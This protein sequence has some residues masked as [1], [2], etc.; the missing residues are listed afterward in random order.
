[1]NLKVA[2]MKVVWEGE[3]IELTAVSDPVIQPRLREIIT[4]HQR[5]WGV[6]VFVS[7]TLDEEQRHLVRLACDLQFVTPDSERPVRIRQY[8]ELL[9][10]RQLQREK[11]VLKG[12]E[13]FYAARTAVVNDMVATAK[14]D[15]PFPKRLR[16]SIANRFA[17]GT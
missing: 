11:L 9:V 12:S 14:D 13:E 1:M 6:W 16:D 3:E 4:A 2:R 15:R 17:S 5:L 8:Y 7:S 10:D